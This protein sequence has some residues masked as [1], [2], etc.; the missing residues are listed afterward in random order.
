MTVTKIRPQPETPVI[1]NAVDKFAA[2]KAAMVAEAM[3][4]PE[5]VAAA[6]TV[7]DKSMAWASRE[8][9]GA[10][11]KST[12]SQKAQDIEKAMTDRF[13]KNN[14]VGN[15]EDIKF[16]VELMLGE[17]LSLPFMA[18]VNKN[19]IKVDN[20][21][22]VK[23]VANIHEHSYPL[24]SVIFVNQGTKLCGML[25]DG[26]TP[27]VGYGMDEEKTSYAIPTEAEILAA[28]ASLYSLAPTRF[29]EFM[30]M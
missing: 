14:N 2:M 1:P 3:A 12:K 20:G 18:I 28:L 29:E 27:R 22:A 19:R 9:I 13:E 17:E 7:F 6:K 4:L 10:P 25:S 11:A 5:I 23:M 16:A 30:A 26:I 21:I 24:N 15:W 8:G